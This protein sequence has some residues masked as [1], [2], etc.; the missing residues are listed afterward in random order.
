M[1][2]GEQEGDPWRTPRFQ[3]GS[4]GM[5]VPSQKCTEV[6]GLGGTMGGKVGEEP[7]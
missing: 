4:P 7:V 2:A 3:K 5:G 6:P 1:K